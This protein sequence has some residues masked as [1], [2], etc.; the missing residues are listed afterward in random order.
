MKWPAAALTLLGTL[1]TI[2][3]IAL[4]PEIAFS[5]P[6]AHNKGELNSSRASKSAPPTRQP[7]AQ[8]VGGPSVPSAGAQKHSAK[9]NGGSAAGPSVLKAAFPVLRGLEGDVA[10]RQKGELLK[11][12]LEGRLLREQVLVETQKGRV[13]ID[14]SDNEFVV[15]SENSQFLLP[16]IDWETG[17]VEEL[18][19]RQGSF[20]IEITTPRQIRSALFRDRVGPGR[21]IFDFVPQIPRF[22]ATVLNGEIRFRGLETEESSVLGPGDRQTFTG[23]IADGEIQYDILL[24]GRRVA[25]GQLDPKVVVAARDLEAI[26]KSFNQVGRPLRAKSAKK[27]SQTPGAGAPTNA[28]RPT[29]GPETLCRNPAGRFNDCAYMCLNNPKAKKICDLE[30]PKVSCVRRRCL[31]S[32]QWGDEFVY[33][34]HL[35]VCEARSVVRTCDY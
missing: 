20:G 19:I 22:G 27:K 5:A 21:F 6:A 29:S 28:P 25:R 1:G 18:E 34:R 30:N 2:G 8:S 33:P 23:E 11:G 17:K 13:R 12:K 14:L 7:A 3:P 32:G 16:A 26:Q 10:I 35:S 31:A 15:V 4:T 24:E 9:S